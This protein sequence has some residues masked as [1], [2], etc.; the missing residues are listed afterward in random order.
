MSK[1]TNKTNKTVFQP[2]EKADFSV[3]NPKDC[4]AVVV[5]DG[6][7]FVYFESKSKENISFLVGGA[8]GLQRVI[9]LGNDG[10]E[11]DSYS[12]R[13]E[14]ETKIEDKGGKYSYLLTSLYYTMVHWQEASN[15]LLNGK[16]YKYFV[17][18]LRDH[19]HTLKGMKYFYADLKSAIE[20]YRDTQREDGMI[21]D[22]VN[23][24]PEKDYWEQRFGY[25]DFV[26]VY[27][28]DEIEMRRIPVEND[29]EY[30]YI[31]GIYYTWK[32]TG[33]DA[34]MEGFLDSAIKAYQYSLKDEYRFSK[35]FGLLK[36]GYTIDTWDFQSNFH[37][38]DPMVIDKKNTAFGVMHG[39][40]TGFAVG[41]RYLAEM[42]EYVGRNKDA[43]KYRELG[44]E[45][46]ANLDKVSWNGSFYTHHVAE[47]KKTVP[48][49]G[50]DTEKQ[51]SLSNAYALNRDLTDE[52]CS[53]I[54][55]TY[56]NIKKE[57]PEGSPGEWYAIYPPFEKGFSG[58]KGKWQYMNGGVISIVAGE[59]AHGAYEHGYEEYASDILER[60]GALAKKHN[61]YLD[62]THLGAIEPAPKTTFEMLEI[63]SLA[64]VDISGK[65]T[66][67]VVGWTGEGENDLREMPVG[68]KT[69]EDIPFL[70]P[71]PAKNGRR[72]CIGLSV[73]EGYASH[74]G[75][76]VNTKAESI[77]F[78]HAM[79]GSDLAGELT[80]E[81]TDGTSVT[82][83]IRKNSEVLH[84]WMPSN[85]D[86]K[87]KKQLNLRMVDAGK[88]PVCER[89]SVSLF[90]MDNPHPGKTI[91]QLSLNSAKDGS[92]WAI[93]G[94]TLSN[95]KVY[96]KPNDVSQGIPDN[97]GAAAVVYALVEGLAGVVDKS[98]CF[99]DVLIAPRWQSAGVDK[100]FVSV[101]YPASDGYAAYQY[102]H[103]AKTRSIKIDITGNAEEGA[104]HVMLPSKI[105]KVKEV[106]VDG[107]ELSFEIST[108]EKTS[109]VDFGAPIM[110]V[111]KVEIKY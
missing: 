14:C 70:I 108:V 77:Y 91:Y 46:K 10:D 7:G 99:N 32:A 79:D 16:I 67:G 74:A 110:G 37:S 51:V 18:W 111:S 104:F 62:C 75:V 109:Y 15:S 56:Q 92:F 45:I 82:K 22:N 33:D 102:N 9:L 76:P 2:L 4:A 30:L 85:P 26:R 12:F 42:L 66:K 24:H 38:K 47:D 44:K 68:K 29:V 34:W 88:N 83:Y 43:K 95:Q 84:W 35:K 101:T 8:L 69:F 52:Q 40:N 25:G 65:G 23:A 21:W 89:V 97:W 103:S 78:I 71:D 55:K 48:D 86:P 98:T 73:K 96:F 17:R 81:Y 31:E 87:G 107:I 19:V 60:V 13:L 94:I 39:D 53:A 59:L 1:I 57:L 11:I 27:E 41:C 64:N 3:Q 80:I 28:K 100:T 63:S 90:G 54:I 58:H 5:I 20:L 105:K 61:G 93:F 49:F 72:A 50:V 6:A 106:L 36:R